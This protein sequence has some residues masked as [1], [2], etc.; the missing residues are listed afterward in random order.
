V[1]CCRITPRPPYQTLAPLDLSDPASWARWTEPPPPFRL[2]DA[3]RFWAAIAAAL[4]A[5]QVVALRLGR[6]PGL[7]STG[8]MIAFARSAARHAR[9]W[10][11]LALAR[12]PRLLA[13]TH[14][15][16]QFRLDPGRLRRS[17]SPG[18]PLTPM[19][20]WA[21]AAVP[22][23]RRYVLAGRPA[24]V[25]VRRPRSAS[26]AHSPPESTRGTFAT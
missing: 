11:T 22:L 17:L 2:G 6:P 1:E 26:I 19:M 20:N 14:D 21:R 9:D 18:N 23:E 10:E 12:E 5:T 4:T 8:A 15:D 13:R 24:G 25:R 16:L 7:T 3:T